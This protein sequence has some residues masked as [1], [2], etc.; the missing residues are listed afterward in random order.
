MIIKP[1]F[2]QVNPMEIKNLFFEWNLD[3]TGNNIRNTEQDKL[4]VKRDSD[5]S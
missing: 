4:K 1:L 5:I 2:N 3:K